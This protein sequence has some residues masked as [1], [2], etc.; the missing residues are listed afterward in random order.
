MRLEAFTEAKTHGA[1]DTNE[2]SFLLLPGRAY[3]V[4]DGVTDR[5]GTRYGGMLSGRYASRLIVETLETLLVPAG[6]PL[7]QPWLAVEAATGALRGA[8]DAHGVTEAVR[9]D[10]NRQMAATLAL[11]T[12][13]DEHAHV[14]LLGDSG[15]RLNGE[16]VWQEGKDI[17][18]VTATLRAVA[19]AA[20][21]CRTDDPA[22]RERVSR[23][24]CWGGVAHAAPSAAPF[25]NE[26]D[27]RAVADCTVA[28]CR[29]AL[30][31][32]PGDAI[33]AVV[34]GGIV[35]AQ[36]GHQNNPASPFGY[37]SLNGFPVPRTMV[38]TERVPRTRLQTLELFTDG[39]FAPGRTFGV[40]S[41]E[42][43][44]REVEGEDPHKV[45]PFA[46]TKGTTATQWAD[47][48]TYLG[49]AF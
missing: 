46:S 19:W 39:Y 10:W 24:V 9:E 31:H 11:V 38:R 12:L 8:Y 34:E 35:H 17:D 15:V 16:T 49:V 6:A 26:A 23:A 7:D 18:T 36:G 40:E 33:A 14:L 48:R 28:R 29:T 20:V 27:L 41:W 25:L 30:P 4:V 32:L 44:F 3:A 13:T 5:V 37:P 1:P 2:D 47:D 43:R 21:A 42:Q 45:G 22:A